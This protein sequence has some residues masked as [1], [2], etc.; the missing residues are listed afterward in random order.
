MSLFIL[1]DPLITSDEYKAH[2]LFYMAVMAFA[3]VLINGSTT[4]Y[5]LQALGLLKMTSEQLQVLEHVLQVRSMICLCYGRLASGVMG[6]AV[7]AAL[8]VAHS[9]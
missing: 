4:K 6:L 8:Q 9:S 1:V 7:P 5:L 3:T 2:A